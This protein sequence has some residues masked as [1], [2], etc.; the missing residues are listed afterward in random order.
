MFIEKKE[1]CGDFTCNNGHCIA[2]K[3]RCNGEDDCEDMSDELNCP[4]ELSIDS[5]NI[6]SSRNNSQTC[7]YACPSDPEICLPSSAK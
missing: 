5:G 3:L 7:P 4:K 6:T 1:G 2:E